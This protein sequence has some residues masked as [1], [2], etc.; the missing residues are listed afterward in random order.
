MVRT[1]QLF[2]E[3]M[4]EWMDLFEVFLD[5]VFSEVRDRAWNT[6]EGIISNKVL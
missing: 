5:E 2:T 1:Q 6:T 4:K 3:W